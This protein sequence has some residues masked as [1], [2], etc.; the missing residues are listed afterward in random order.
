MV[1]GGEMRVGVRTSLPTFPT[2]S[3]EGTGI[4]RPSAMI[5]EP[6]ELEIKR[7]GERWSVE[8]GIEAEVGGGCYCRYCCDCYTEAGAS[9]TLSKLS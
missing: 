7:A 1:S 3:V 5:F 2:P 6:W 8:V 9:K 4:S